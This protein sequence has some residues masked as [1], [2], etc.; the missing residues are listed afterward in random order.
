M[1]LTSSAQ[2]QYLRSFLA[3][4]GLRARTSSSDLRPPVVAVAWHTARAARAHARGAPR[5]QKSPNKSPIQQRLESYECVV[6]PPT[7]SPLPPSRAAAARAPWPLSARDPGACAPGRRTEASGDRLDER[8]AAVGARKKVSPSPSASHT[9][10][11]HPWHG[12]AR[13]RTPSPPPHP[14]PRP[15]PCRQGMLDSKAATL[16]KYQ[17]SVE[18]KNRQQM[19]DLTNKTLAKQTKAAEN[20]SAVLSEKVDKA[21]TAG[22]KAGLISESNQESVRQAPFASC[23]TPRALLTPQV[24]P[25]SLYRCGKSA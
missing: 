6:P 3:D 1:P 18:A 22:E 12:C 21:T 19:D 14:A 11:A 2:K 16:G 13:G 23:P 15:L 25:G 20:R 9:R 5:M 8:F 4:F 7:P 17:G 10:R 24:Q